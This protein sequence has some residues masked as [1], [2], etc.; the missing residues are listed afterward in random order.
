[1]AYTYPFTAFCSSVINTKTGRKN[2]LNP[3]KQQ[4]LFTRFGLNRNQIQ[5]AKSMNIDRIT[6]E[7][8]KELVKASRAST[9]DSR[10]AFGW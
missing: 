2:F 5:A 7:L 8:R 4:M 10:A 1:M 9:G 3:K 6:D